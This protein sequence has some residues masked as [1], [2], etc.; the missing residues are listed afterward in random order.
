VAQHE[1]NLKKIYDYLVND[2]QIHRSGSNF[3][4]DVSLLLFS[5]NVEKDVVEE[6]SQYIQDISLRE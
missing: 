3:T 5:R 2:L 4:D 1:K 6:D